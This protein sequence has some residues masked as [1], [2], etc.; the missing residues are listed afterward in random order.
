MTYYRLT[1]KDGSHSAWTTNKAL[2]EKDAKF[3]HATIETK[4]V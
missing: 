4:E 1:F 3:F 2:V